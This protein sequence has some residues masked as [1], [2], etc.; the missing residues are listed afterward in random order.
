MTAPTAAHVL[1]DITSEMLGDHDITDLLARHLRRASASL[2]AA[3][4]GIL[5]GVSGEPLELLSATS[6]AVTELEVFQSQV[7]EGPCVD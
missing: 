7:D 4:M 2:D 1:A 6:H 3:A 5:L